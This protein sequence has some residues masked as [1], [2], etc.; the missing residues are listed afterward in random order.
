M[1]TMTLMSN[2]TS[3]IYYPPI[4]LP[5]NGVHHISFMTSKYQKYLQ[6][7]FS[8]QKNIETNPFHTT[9]KGIKTFC[10]GKCRDPIIKRI[11]II[12][13]EKE[14]QEGHTSFIWFVLFRNIISTCS[15]HKQSD[16]TLIIQICFNCYLT[17]RWIDTK[18]ATMLTG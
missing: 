14:L 6:S 17:I 10:F 2:F 18:F 15:K 11:I 1:N 13:N 7:H 9:Q 5:H 3:S 12:S 4:L 16:I 8:F